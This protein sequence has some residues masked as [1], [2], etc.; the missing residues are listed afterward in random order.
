MTYQPPFT[1]TT[2]IIDL[3]SAVSEQVGF[4]QRDFLDAPVNALQNAP[5]NLMSV[6][7]DQVSDYVGDQ[8]CQF[9]HSGG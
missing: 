1:I 4:V 3:I 8:V 7:T 9:A 6:H 2:E 5:V